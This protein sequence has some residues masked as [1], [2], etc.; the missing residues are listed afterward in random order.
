MNT[1]KT[2][3][4]LALIL[5]PILLTGQQWK[6]VYENNA[7]GE[8]ISGNKADLLAAVNSGS[9]V[10]VSWRFEPKDETETFI[11]HFATADLVSVLNEDQVYVQVSFIREHYYRKKK[12][13]I[14]FGQTSVTYLFS[15]SDNQLSM[16][17]NL[18]GPGPG[19]ES[20]LKRLGSV[21]WFVR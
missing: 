17:P 2:N 11:E 4:L 18:A 5:I 14:S 20:K 1:L 7:E 15:T 3:L 9:E 6:Q 8:K 16:S 19:I 13:E 12:E 10:R 21:R